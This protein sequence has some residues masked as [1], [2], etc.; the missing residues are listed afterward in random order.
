M[1]HPPKPCHHTIKLRQAESGSPGPLRFC[2]RVATPKNVV[3]APAPAQRRN[4]VV[5]IEL[6]GDDPEVQTHPSGRR[7][8][9]LGH[10]EDL[11]APEVHSTP[12]LELKRVHVLFA[13]FAFHP[14]RVV[15]VHWGQRKPN[16]HLPR[17]AVVQFVAVRMA[18][19]L[20]AG[21]VASQHWLALVHEPVAAAQFL[22]DDLVHEEAVQPAERLRLLVRPQTLIP[23]ALVDEC[24]APSAA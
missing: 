17:L 8:V 21:G 1:P 23:P 19:R 10:M 2:V 6:L 9:G 12:P 16:V 7:V 3:C 14:Q 13:S 20:A 24:G 15:A 22:G 11:A 18:Q 5:D 4:I